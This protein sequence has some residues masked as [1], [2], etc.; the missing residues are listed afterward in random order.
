MTQA[1]PYAITVIALAVLAA[2]MF[3][4]PCLRIGA[5][6]EIDYN[7]GWNAFLQGLVTAGL[8]PYAGA[9]ALFFNNYPPLSFYL[10]GLLGLAVGDPVLAGRLLS[11]VAVAVIAASSGVVVR[12][13]GGSRGDGLLAMATCTAMFSAFA[14]DY[15]G[16]DDPQLLAQGFLAAGF[17]V[18]VGGR[19][20]PARLAAVAVLF[21]LG[22]L[23]KH[24]VLALPLVVSVHALWRAPAAGRWTFLAVGLTLIAIAGTTILA[25]FGMDFFHRLLAPRIYD[26]TRGFL[27]TMEVLERI[28]APLAVAGFFLLLRHGDGPVPTMVAAYLLGS[29]GLGMAFSGGAGVDINIFFDTM[30]AAAMGGGLAATWLRRQPGLPAMAPALLA[31]LANF[32]VLLLTPQ[33]LGRMAVD[34][35]GEYGERQRLFRADVAYLRQIPGPA[36][37]ESMLLCVRAGKAIAVDPYN[38]LQASLTGRLPP[39]LLE[40]MLARH[41]FPVFQVSSLREHPLDEAP[42]LQVI[43]PR[44][45]NFSDGVFDE[46]A[47]SYTLDRVGLSGRFYRP[48]QPAR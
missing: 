31:V 29:L 9:G 5:D 10:V 16:V 38:V 13:N 18:Y 22:L 21:A 44:F 17:A 47:R 32:G 48:V 45:V 25:L 24:N 23:C 33:V 30:I 11:V 35:L 36:V 6:F 34:A 40:D 19:A 41:Q 39:H 4:Y 28:Q 37:C 26:V 46:L 15:V 3:A 8:S 27:L 2:I 1:R 43:P 20:G 7:E 14:T 42:G 12:A